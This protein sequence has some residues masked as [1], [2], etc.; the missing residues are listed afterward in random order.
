[1]AR[2]PCA[3]G[4]TSA[5]VLELSNF[6]GCQQQWMTEAPHGQQG[7]KS[8][9][10]WHRFG[11]MVSPGGGRVGGGGGYRGQVRRTRVPQVMLI[12]AT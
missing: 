7:N 12:A 11:D 9:P 1:M 6:Q 10:N 2:F 4:E 3:D 5:N 8:H